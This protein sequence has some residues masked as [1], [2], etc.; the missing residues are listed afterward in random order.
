MSVKLII[1]SQGMLGQALCVSVGDKHT[2][3]V[4]HTDLDITDKAAVNAFFT[5]YH[6][7]SVYN[8]AAYNAVDACENDTNEQKKA[9]AV[10]E[11]G[12][13]YLAECAAVRQ[14]PF[15]TVSTDYVFD[16]VKG[17]Y[18]EDNVPNPVSV[19]GK[20][21]YAGERAVREVARRYPLWRWYVVRTSKLFGK[22]GL[23]KTAKQSF[24][25]KIRSVLT[26]QNTAEV[27]DG[28]QSCFTYVPDLAEALLVLEQHNT[29]SGIY[30]LINELPATWYGGAV[31]LVKILN[32]RASLIPIPPERMPR[33]APR[34]NRSV[35]VNT[36]QRKLRPYT[37]A[38]RE[39]LLR[40]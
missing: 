25:E 38:L 26:T 29:P 24:F 39:Y 40:S 15:I 13:R 27:I 9:F 7:E 35:L 14:I 10:N 31:Q 33:P 28:E 8:T 23:T 32:L 12:V 11:Q 22:P 16:G 4:D 30:H 36:K 37:E 20:S 2:I 6:P 18:T 1:G 5:K 3:G 34:P 21:K 17:V 19:Y